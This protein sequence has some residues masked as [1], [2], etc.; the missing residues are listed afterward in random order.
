M[1][2]ER[3]DGEWVV[4]VQ[5]YRQEGEEGEIEEWGVVV[6]GTCGREESQER[7]DVYGRVRRVCTSSTSSSKSLAMGAV[8]MVGVALTLGVLLVVVKRRRRAVKWQV[9]GDEESSVL[10]DNSLSVSQS[11]DKALPPIHKESIILKETPVVLKTAVKKTSLLKAV[12]SDT[13]L[14]TRHSPQVTPPV[15]RTL[16]HIDMHSLDSPLLN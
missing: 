14:T 8:L 1:W 6:Y 10:I 12:S 3:V 5:D 2:G 7:V 13:L 9:V 15:R 4:E 11:V 16:S